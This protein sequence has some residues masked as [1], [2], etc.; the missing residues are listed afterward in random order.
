MQTSTIKE[1]HSKESEIKRNLEFKKYYTD[2][3]YLKGVK[4]GYATISAK[5]KEE[6]YEDV[7]ETRIN[8]T[9]VEPFVVRPTHI[10]YL[11]P[12]TRF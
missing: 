4:T 2:V 11:L 10:V 3:L 6:G 8:I 1:A 12:T 7:K 5:I 9:V